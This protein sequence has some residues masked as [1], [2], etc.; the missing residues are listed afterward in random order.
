MYDYCIN[1]CV[2]IILMFMSLNSFLKSSTS[3]EGNPEMQILN[4]LITN[5]ETKIQEFIIKAT[6]TTGII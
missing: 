5:N 2:N 4:F 1:A 3:L 6:E